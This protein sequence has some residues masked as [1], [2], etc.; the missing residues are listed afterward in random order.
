MCFTVIAFSEAQVHGEEMAN[1]HEANFPL[2]I[3]RRKETSKRLAD[4]YFCLSS[5]FFSFICRAT[6]VYW[7]GTLSA[8]GGGTSH[9]NSDRVLSF[10]L[11]LFVYPR[12]RC[13]LACIN[14]RNGNGRRRRSSFP[15]DLLLFAPGVF[16]RCRNN[17]S[18]RF[19]PSR[20][21]FSSS[22]CLRVCCLLDRLPQ[23]KKKK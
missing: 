20:C 12:E 18:F 21:L 6:C 1:D 2:F 22:R 4:C 17:I 5:T 23:K 10:V 9:T 8:G 16:T 19:V 14:K 11:F 15:I 7:L 13:K 3:W